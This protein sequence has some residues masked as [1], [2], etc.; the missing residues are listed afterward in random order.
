MQRKSPA[1]GL[2]V[3]L[4][5]ASNAQ[6]LCGKTIGYDRS[7]KHE[8]VSHVVW[9]GLTPTLVFSI[10]RRQSLNSVI[11]AGNENCEMRFVTR[12]KI[13]R[14]ELLFN[15]VKLDRLTIVT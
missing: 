11:E 12:Y 3:G 14:Y 15:S 7:K 6:I 13:C 1:N 4:S 8:S 9:A 10:K 5:T 2:V